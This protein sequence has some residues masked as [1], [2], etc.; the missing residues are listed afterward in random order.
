M[1]NKAK[2]TILEKN[3]AKFLNF[4]QLFAKYAWI[5]RKFFRCQ[6]YSSIVQSIDKLVIKFCYTVVK[7]EKFKTISRNVNFCHVH[8]CCEFGWDC[9]DDLFDKSLGLT[10]PNQRWLLR[11]VT[12]VTVN[13]KPQSL[14]Q[15][16]QPHFGSETP[17]KCLLFRF[18]H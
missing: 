2:F 16:S 10:K 5:S 14:V 8:T 17:D 11:E 7:L 3:S 12:N 4:K 9:D 6:N 15:W 18:L 1:R 13:R